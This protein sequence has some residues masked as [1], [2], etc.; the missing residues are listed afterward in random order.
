MVR[1]RASVRC[2]TL[3]SDALC[4]SVPPS[5]PSGST[6]E[7]SGPR[8]RWAVEELLGILQGA[9]EEG[10]GPALVALGPLVSGD[11]GQDRGAAGRVESLGE[12][13]SLIVASRHDETR[14]Q[15]ESRFVGVGFRG[16]LH[17]H[18]LAQ[19]RAGGIGVPCLR[20]IK[21]DSAQGPDRVDLPGRLKPLLVDPA[22]DLHG[23][24]EG[25]ELTQRSRKR[26]AIFIRVGQ[27]LHGRHG[28]P[29]DRQAG[30]FLIGCHGSGRIDAGIGVGRRVSELGQHPGLIPEAVPIRPLA[31][32]ARDDGDARPQCLFSGADRELGF[33]EEVRGPVANPPALRAVDREVEGLDRRSGGSLIAELA[34]GH[35]DILQRPGPTVP[36]PFG[37]SAGL[38]QLSEAPLL[39]RRP[40]PAPWRS[41]HG[42]NTG[43]PPRVHSLPP[44]PDRGWSAPGLVAALDQAQTRAMCASSLSC[45][46]LKP[47]TARDACLS[48][49]TSGFPAGRSG[50]AA[51]FVRAGGWGDE[52]SSRAPSGRL[53]PAAHIARAPNTPQ[54][55]AAIINLVHAMVR[56]VPS[57]RFA[58]MAETTVVAARPAASWRRGGVGG[59]GRAPRH[60]R[61]RGRIGSQGCDQ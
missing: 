16:R 44:P 56:K 10:L 30:R 43:V 46:S 26:G 41:G 39:C 42:H 17:P 9:P 37:I 48:V 34:L 4:L 40:L 24:V 29:D 19:G 61:R 18:R 8:G 55:P 7:S 28:T 25:A 47:A 33:G 27:C 58:T 32:L 60:G 13:H 20:L 31:S 57:T 12:L 45:G 53:I 52:G 59:T 14:G 35:G 36:K 21:A 50:S 5:P 15:A 54:I 49:S 1:A 2:L 23:L 3:A 22:G 6:E 11:L 38:R 51:A